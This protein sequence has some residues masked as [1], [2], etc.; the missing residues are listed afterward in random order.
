MITVLKVVGFAD[1]D[2]DEGHELEL[3]KA[4]A[5]G[6]RQR[7]QVAQVSDLR[8]DQVATQLARPLRRLAGIE[9]AEEYINK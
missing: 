8:V 5:S 7:E 2:A 3:R 4:L 9:A 1:V 6:R